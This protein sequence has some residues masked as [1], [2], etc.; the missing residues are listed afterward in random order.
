MKPMVYGVSS[1]FPLGPTYIYLQCVLSKY[2][3]CFVFTERL[4][5]N[6]YLALHP[7]PTRFI[8]M[9]RYVKSKDLRMIKDV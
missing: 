3:V 8:S 4:N 7:Q 5:D 9:S 1:G 6:S 2:F